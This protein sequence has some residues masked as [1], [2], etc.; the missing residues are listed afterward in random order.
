MGKNFVCTKALSL[1]QYNDSA[2]KV[3]CEKATAILPGTKVTVSEHTSP[4]IPKSLIRATMGDDFTF[5]LDA[6]TF[7]EHFSPTE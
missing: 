1:S 5:Y 4:T 6:A 7:A 2:T 3:L